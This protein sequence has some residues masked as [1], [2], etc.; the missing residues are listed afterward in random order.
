MKHNIFL[1]EIFVQWPKRLYMVWSL[2]TFLT[3]LLQHSFHYFFL[4]TLVLI[5][6]PNI[7]SLPWDLCL[8][9]YIYVSVFPIPFSLFS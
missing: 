1:N 8:C 6:F 2:P 9:S 7:L 3:Y 4:T 5:C